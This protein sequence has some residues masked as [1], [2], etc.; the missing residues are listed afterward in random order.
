MLLPMTLKITPG[1][2]VP[3][4][5]S[6]YIRH[7]EAAKS[8]DAFQAGSAVVPCKERMA[9]NDAGPFFIGFNCI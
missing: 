3:N 8:S 4:M 5:E 1:Y 6:S 2:R 9:R 7:R